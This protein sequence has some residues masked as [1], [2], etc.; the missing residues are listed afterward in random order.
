MDTTEKNNQIIRLAL[1][2][3]EKAQKIVLKEKILI[4]D[5]DVANFYWNDYS[6]YLDDTKLKSFLDSWQM[7][8][9][10]FD[11]SSFLNSHVG[12]IT[13]LSI[14]RIH[15][16]F[17]LPS[18]TLSQKN[19][20]ILLYDA[21]SELS[22]HLTKKLIQLGAD[23]SFTS[24]KE[25]NSVSEHYKTHIF[26]HKNFRSDV[27]FTNLLSTVNNFF[28][29]DKKENKT[30]NNPNYKEF[31]DFI[32][33][34]SLHKTNSIRNNAQAILAFAIANIEDIP[35]FQFNNK[36]MIEGWIN[37]LQR[38]PYN[39]EY[40]ISEFKK[41]ENEDKANFKKFLQKFIIA[42]FF[43]KIDDK[44]IYLHLLN[45]FNIKNFNSNPLKSYME[46]DL[47]NENIVFFE[48]ALNARIVENT[49]DKRKSPQEPKPKTKANKI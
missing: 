23:I 49:L 29:N 6:T 5:M 20:D 40:W 26:K 32:S 16:I 34:K 46:K 35:P 30:Y 36:I 10:K 47:S 21:Y 18:K 14:V 3:N 24:L 2:N 38:T 17:N 9:S 22:P 33:Y 37:K 27:G 25:D 43:Q 12:N 8:H 42:S 15:E 4:S 1:G 19:K 44:T 39:E 48:R 28:E 7:L 11:F 45:N 41:Y 31:I 13:T